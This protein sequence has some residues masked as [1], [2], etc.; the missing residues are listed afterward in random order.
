MMRVQ[1]EIRVGV[2]FG[3]QSAEHDVSMMSAGSV[4]DALQD[5]H[6]LVPIAITREG[7]WIA[8]QAALDYMASETGRAPALTISRRT[9]V[10]APQVSAT[11]EEPFR[12]E[13]LH[14]LADVVIPLLHGPLGEDG[15]VQGLLE[16]AGMPYVGSG[17]LGS[18]LGMDKIAMKT[19][20][21]AHHIPQVAFRAVMRQAWNRARPAVLA[22]LEAAL[23]YPMFVKPANLGS[24]VGIS[25]ASQRV[26][27]EEAITLAMHHDRR[28]I[29]E[30]GVN[31]REFEVGVLGWE[32]AEASVAGEVVVH[33]HAFYD[34]EAKDGDATTELTIPAHISGEVSEEMRTLAIKAFHV[35]D[36]AGLARVDFFYDRESG[37]VLLNEVNTLP[38]FTPFSMYPVLWEATGVSYSQLLERLIQLAFARHRGF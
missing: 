38:G 34:Y 22:D 12:P 24:S 5:T 36:C 35:L 26:E 30:Q 25:K 7:R 6:V 20:L 31:A 32:E 33:G 4:M 16:L 1:K 15:T 28:V 8:G 18:A 11:P 10:S 29:I 23:P 17:V 14:R 27:L 19:M 21:G 9:E 13:G 3:G 2:L 37:A